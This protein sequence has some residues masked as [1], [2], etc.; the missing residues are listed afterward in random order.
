MG[1][2]NNYS[3]FKEDVNNVKIIEE[4]IYKYNLKIYSQIL[5]KRL[6]NWTNLH[7]KHTPN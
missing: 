3:I 6:T 5:F 1:R 2:K 4:E 7:N